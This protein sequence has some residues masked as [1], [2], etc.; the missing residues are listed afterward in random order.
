VIDPY[1]GYTKML[2]IKNREPDKWKK[3]HRFETPN[4]YVIRG[5]TGEESV[6]YSS[7]GN[8]G[9]LFDIY[10][11]EWSEKMMEE[12]GVPRGLFPE[13][14]ISSENIVGE[15]TAKGSKATGLPKGTPI[16]AGGIDASVSALAGGAIEDGDLASMLGTSM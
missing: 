9:G 16:C 13:H 15:V 1:Y 11:R 14:I 6:D 5:L 12:L 3:I 8:Y 4:A 10:K 7:A 2:W